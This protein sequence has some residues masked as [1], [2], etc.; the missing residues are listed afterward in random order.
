MPKE[1]A[2]GWELPPVVAVRRSLK[3]SRRRNATPLV[4]PKP[5]WTSYSPPPPG[6]PIML[7]LYWKESIFFYFPKHTLKVKFDI[8]IAIIYFTCLYAITLCF[9][10]YLKDTILAFAL[11]NY[12]HLISY[13]LHLKASNYIRSSSFITYADKPIVYILLIYNKLTHRPSFHISLRSI[14]NENDC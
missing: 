8:L 4:Q 6:R 7:T 10:A 11:C 2:F 13:T 5:N 9:L 12:Y 3:V 1:A 14:V